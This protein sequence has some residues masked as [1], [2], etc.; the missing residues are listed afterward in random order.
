MEFRIIFL[1]PSRWEEFKALRLEALT[2]DPHAFGRS[3]AEELGYSEKKWKR[4]LLEKSEDTRTTPLFCEHDGRLVGMM[5]VFVKGG[6]KTATI[7][8]VYVKPEYRTK[9]IGKMLL[10]ELLMKLKAY[11]NISK[12]DLTVNIDQAAAIALY[13]S[14]GFQITRIEDMVL[15]D[16]KSHK[17]YVMEKVLRSKD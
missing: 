5:G 7:W 16:G 4:R 17:E 12:I 9:G 3:H 10:E 2:T 13:K 8:G 15:G 6:K 11:E 14:F 1:P